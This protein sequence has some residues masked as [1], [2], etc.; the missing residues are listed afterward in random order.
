MK[1]FARRK[2]GTFIL[3]AAVLG[4]V[5]GRLDARTRRERV[6][7]ARRVGTRLPVFAASQRPL[8]P[9]DVVRAAVRHPADGRG[10]TCLRPVVR[11]AR[12]TQPPRK[13]VG[14]VRS[15]SF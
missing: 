9:A 13:D 3:G 10:D 8:G 7:R 5:A 14:D 12:G 4:I 1:S 11:D 6:G 2:P 15:D